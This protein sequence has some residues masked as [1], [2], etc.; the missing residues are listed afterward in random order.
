MDPNIIFNRIVR[1]ARLDTSVFD[2][3]RDDVNETIPAII[4]AVVSA[5]LAGLGS[6]LWWSLVPNSSYADS[7]GNKVLDT[8]ILGSIFLVALYGVAA[9]IV[10]VVLVQLYKVQLDLLSLVR[11]LGYAALP[12]AGSLLMFIPAIW[13][14]FAIVPLALLVIA[15]IYAVQAASGADSTQ[16]VVATIAGFSVMVLVLGLIA[17][18]TSAGDAPMGAGLFSVLFDLN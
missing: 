15:M 13:P 6:L 4:I 14:V 5:F 18:S 10:Y 7:A 17:T 9:L 1:L 2:E 16:V 11:V 3:V 12:M 8:F